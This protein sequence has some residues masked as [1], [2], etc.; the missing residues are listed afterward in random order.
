[1]IRRIHICSRDGCR[2]WANKSGKCPAHE[3]VSER[4]PS[5]S[6]VAPYSYSW[7][8]RDEAGRFVRQHGG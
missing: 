7:R 1:M 4:K 3:K 2:A 6:E 8:K 5:R